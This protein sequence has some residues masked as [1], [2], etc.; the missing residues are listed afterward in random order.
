MEGPGGYQFVGRTCQMWNRIRQ[1]E[2]FVDGKPWLLRFFDQV[3]FYPVSAEELLTFREDFPRGRVKLRV[4]PATFRLGDYSAFLRDNGA[5]IDAFKKTQQ[6]AFEE[7]RERWKAL[8]EVV[9]PTTVVVEESDEPTL[10]PGETA[11]RAEVTGSVWQVPVEVGQQ[12]K[13]GERLVILETMKMETPI[14][15]PADGVVRKVLVRAGAL[16]RVGQVL[17]I[18]G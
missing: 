16:V 5:S 12:V 10:A 9:E 7:E 14:V 4:E 8:P 13:A 18:L 3:R 11:V 15:A 17:A 2:D 1:T 6:Q